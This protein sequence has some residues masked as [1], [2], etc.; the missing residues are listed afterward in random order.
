M[1]D[2]VRIDSYS[3]NFNWLNSADRSTCIR[4]LL[5]DGAPAKCLSDTWPEDKEPHWEDE[6]PSE[7]VRLIKRRVSEYWSTAKD[8]Q[9]ALIAWCE[10]HSAEL[11]HSWATG[12]IVVMQKEHAALHV[13]I[14]R[15]R[16]EFLTDDDGELLPLRPFRMS[17]PGEVTHV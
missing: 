17:V 13:E 3:G 1:T 5:P 9:L 14:D 11:D 12:L 15:I 16:Y 7:V 2:Y 8:K 6:P 10:A 4:I